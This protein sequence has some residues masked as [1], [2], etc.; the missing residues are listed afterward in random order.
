MVIHHL[1]QDIFYYKYQQPLTF[2]E[3]PGMKKKSYMT[4]LEIEPGT[5]MWFIYLDAMPRKSYK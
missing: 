1:I 4:R 5:S 2:P 3:H